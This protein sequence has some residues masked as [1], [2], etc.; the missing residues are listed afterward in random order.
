MMSALSWQLLLHIASA[1]APA[2]FISQFLFK[3]LESCV[4]LTN[5]N[6]QLL[7]RNEFEFFFVLLTVKLSFPFLTPPLSASAV[8]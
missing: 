6:F 4:F 5:I 1:L 2:Q 7:N 8:S 3:H